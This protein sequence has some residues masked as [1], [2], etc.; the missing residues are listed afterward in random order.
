VFIIIVD[1]L[2]CFLISEKNVKS[3]IGGCTPLIIRRFVYLY[4]ASSSMLL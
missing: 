2:A 4:W 3:L 1:V